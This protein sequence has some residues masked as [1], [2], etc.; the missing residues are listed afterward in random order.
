MKRNIITPRSNY[1]QKLEDLS[2]K[3]HSLS[4]IYWDESAYYS[5]SLS[6]IDKIEAATEELYK[7]SLDAVQHVIDNDL[8]EQFFI[9]PNLVELIEASWN[10][11]SPSFYGRFDLGYNPVSGAIKLFEFNADTP[12]SLYEAAVVQWKWLEEV[13][14][15]KDQFNSIHEKLLAYWQDTRAYFGG[16]KVYFGCVK[17]S[18]ED[19]TTIEYIR[20]LANQAGISTEQ[21]YMDDIGWHED[22]Q[23][24]TALNERIMK[25][26]FKLYPW[27]WMSNEEFGPNLERGNT[28]WIEPAWKAILSNKA[29]LPILWELYPNHPLLL[30]TYFDDGNARIFK[31]SFSKYVRKPIYSREGAN[32]LIMDGGIPVVETEGE[33]GEEGYIIQEKFDVPEFDGNYP[34]IGSW[35]IDQQAAGMGI[36]EDKT[37]I[38]GNLS[39]FIPHLIE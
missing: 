11:G 19:F 12:T 5:F 18:I 10:V 38:T 20:D 9:N 3:F 24:F 8:Y 25:F 35:V 30:E 33:Y 16:E 17:D 14:A 22:T 6:E 31:N 7:M 26:C 37:L 21:I 13:F 1:Q 32:I 27:E 36:R 29:I 28:C 39:R 23:V 4:T 15:G 34:V 2:F